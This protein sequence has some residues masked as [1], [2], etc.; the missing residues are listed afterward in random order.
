MET[1]S[2]FL[3]DSIGFDGEA[4]AEGMV[5]G[6]EEDA[7]DCAP[8]TQ[9]QLGTAGSR[10]FAQMQGLSGSAALPFAPVISQSEK[11]KFKREWPAFLETSVSIEIGSMY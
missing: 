9:R 2:T 4:P 11:D 5:A 6:L 3:C 1:T 7:V 10:Y 8:S